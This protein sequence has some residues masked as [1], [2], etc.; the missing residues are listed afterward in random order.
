MF[1]F[2]DNGSGKQKLLG[3]IVLTVIISFLL[4]FYTQTILHTV[5]L[6]IV[7]CATLFIT[8]PIWLP[9]ELCFKRL[10]NFQY[11]QKKFILSIERSHRRMAR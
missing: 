6:S 8:R 3:F 1:K 7:I 11:F 4:T 5:I 10:E 9:P 2:F